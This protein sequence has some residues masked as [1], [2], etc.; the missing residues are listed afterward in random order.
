MYGIFTVP[1]FTPE[2]TQMY[3]NIPHMEWIGTSFECWYTHRG[4]S[5]LQTLVQLLGSSKRPAP[6]E[7]LWTQQKRGI[8]HDSSINSSSVC[9][10]SYGKP[11]KLQNESQRSLSR[12]LRVEASK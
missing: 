3:V 11:E 5:S 2:T 10:N 4:P 1:T 6:L 12:Q 8:L 7:I 9:L